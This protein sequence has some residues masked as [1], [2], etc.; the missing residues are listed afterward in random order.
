MA[1]HKTPLAI[2]EILLHV[3]KY[4]DLQDCITASCVSQLWHKT[5]TSVLPSG[6]VL[7]KDTLSEAELDAALEQLNS[8]N[9]RTLEADFRYWV[10]K[11]LNY[12][13][14]RDA[15]KRAWEP[16]KQALILSAE[17]A[18]KDARRSIRLQKLIIRGGISPDE[19][20]L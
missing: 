4:L 16:F 19:D 9:V 6:T 13:R 10:G 12:M 3:S 1:T 5:F 15:Q 20:Y 2:P 8:N 18:D 7:W 17:E 11:A 14:D